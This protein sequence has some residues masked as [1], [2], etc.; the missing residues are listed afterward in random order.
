MLERRNGLP[1]VAGAPGLRALAGRTRTPRQF[2]GGQNNTAP[3]QAESPY[4]AN[5]R[6]GGS[7][8][9]AHMTQAP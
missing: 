3:N 4:L 9:D 5:A 2:R 8:T 1:R 6:T 7:G